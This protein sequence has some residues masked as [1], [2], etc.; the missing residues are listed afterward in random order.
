MLRRANYTMFDEGMPVGSAEC[1]KPPHLLPRGERRVTVH[2]AW[3][4]REAS[5]RFAVGSC[6]RS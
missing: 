5:A 4:L 6:E 2:P 1:R 3:K